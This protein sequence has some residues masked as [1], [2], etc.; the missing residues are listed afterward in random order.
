M[1][2]IQVLLEV[3]SEIMEGLSSGRYVRDA[4]GIIRRA[5]GTDNAGEIVAHLKELTDMDWQ[6]AQLVSPDLLIP[7][8]AFMAVQ[9]AGFVY[10]GYQLKQI[11]KALESLQRD[12]HAILTNVEMIREQQWLDRLNRVAHGA[13]HLL[14]SDFRPNLLDEARSSFREARSE[15]NLFLQNQQPMTLVEYLPQTEQLARGLC[16]AFAGE[17]VCLQKQR[18]DFPEMAHICDRYSGIL[19]ETRSRLAEAPPISRTIP[20]ERYLKHYGG[21]KPLQEKLSTTQETLAGERQFIETLGKIEG[22]CWQEVK[23][24]LP[25]GAEK[26]VLV[27]YP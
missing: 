24:A 16:V 6:P 3:P 4:A 5:K 18:A 1:P 25:P 12:V 23:E 22:D 2:I 8:G 17:F 14:D 10:L 27:V 7:M 20:S 11:R 19:S 26:A 21:L 9:I 15:I 13:E